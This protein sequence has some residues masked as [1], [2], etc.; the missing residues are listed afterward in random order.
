ME[1]SMTV[2]K[3]VTNL[4]AVSSRGWVIRSV[5]GELVQGRADLS[6]GCLFHIL[7]PYVVETVHVVQALSGRILIL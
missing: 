1:V 4:E 3:A 7:M 5:G 2:S 6:P